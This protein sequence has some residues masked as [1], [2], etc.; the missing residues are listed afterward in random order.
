MPSVIRTH[1]AYP[2]RPAPPPPTPP[3]RSVDPNRAITIFRPWTDEEI[4]DLRKLCAD[5]RSY[6]KIG[7][8]IGRAEGSVHKK[9]KML[10]IEKPSCYFGPKKAP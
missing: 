2:E 8:I 9:A 6:K 4:S 1:I 10:G 5:G 3:R 7:E